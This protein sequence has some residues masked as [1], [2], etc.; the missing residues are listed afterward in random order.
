VTIH[1]SHKNNIDPDSS[2]VLRALS[3]SVHAKP[4]YHLRAGLLY[5]HWGCGFL[6][7]NRD[8]AWKGTM[9][10]ARACRRKFD[11]AAGCKARP[12]TALPMHMEMED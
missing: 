3:L 11:A 8:H 12:V 6:T 5:L 7:E 4:K 1:S 10:Q 9:D 2:A